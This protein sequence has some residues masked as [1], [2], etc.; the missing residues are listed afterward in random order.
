MQNIPYIKDTR[1]EINALNA[2]AM[3]ETKPETILDILGKLIQIKKHP[4]YSQDKFWI[5]CAVNIHCVHAYRVQIETVHLS[6]APKDNDINV[7]IIPKTGN[8][9]NV[10]T[11]SKTW[12]DFLKWARMNTAQSRLK[13][14]E[15]LKVEE[16]GDRVTIYGQEEGMG[17]LMVE[18]YFRGSDICWK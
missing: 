2:F 16:E 11:K 1:K 13:E 4:K 17:K 18:K 3:D 9:T 15:S 8:D 6:I 12:D 5:G 14:F 7:A 10:V